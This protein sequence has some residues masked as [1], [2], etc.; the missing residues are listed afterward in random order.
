MQCKSE[1][2]DAMGA[3][4][5]GWANAGEEASDLGRAQTMASVMGGLCK[6]ELQRST[7]HKI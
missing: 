5:W 2:W 7:M 1:E 3:G 6:F 4:G